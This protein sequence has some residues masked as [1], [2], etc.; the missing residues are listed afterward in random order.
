MVAFPESEVMIDGG[1]GRKVL[2]QVAPL[3]GGAHDV[4]H[5]VEQFP[6]GV[7]ARASRLGGFGKTILDE[8][9]FGVRQIMSVSHPQSAG[10]SGQK[11]TAKYADSLDFFEFSNRLLVGNLALIERGIAECFL[12]NVERVIDI[13]AQRTK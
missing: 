1:P 11:S 5:R 3:A 9:P 8:F 4:E 13:L 10:V 6:I 7:L 12:D 2:G